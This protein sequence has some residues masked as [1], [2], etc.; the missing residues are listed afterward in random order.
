M[1][2]LVKFISSGVQAP[3]AAVRRGQGQTR[4]EGSCIFLLTM[5]KLPPPASTCRDLQV[6]ISPLKYFPRLQSSSP[7]MAPPRPG[8]LRPRLPSPTALHTPVAL[9]G[10]HSPHSASARTSHPE[11]ER[12]GFQVSIEKSPSHR[13]AFADSRPS[14]KQHLPSTLHFLTPRGFIHGTLQ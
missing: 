7:A 3:R 9:S 11:T 8:K 12:L 10:P 2:R 6:L 13:E 1:C 14:A 4:E 5:L